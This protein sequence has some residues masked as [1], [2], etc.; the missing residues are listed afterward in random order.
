MQIIDELTRIDPSILTTPPDTLKTKTQMIINETRS[1]ISTIESLKNE[2]ISMKDKIVES[3]EKIRNSKNLPYLV[4]HVAE[5][6]SGD[7][8]DKD[9]KK[10]S[11][12]D[13]NNLDRN[14]NNLDRDKNNLDRDSA[15]V[16]TTTRTSSFLPMA[17]LVETKDLRPG[18]LVALHKETNVIFYKLPPDYD[19]RVKAMEVVERPADTYDDIGGLERQIEELNEAVV[20]PLTHPDKFTRLNIKMPKGVLLYGP[21]GTGKTL[22]ARAVAAR[23][24]ATFLK[25]AG[26]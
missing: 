22:L 20:L 1:I 26:P 6:Y 15:I 18:D 24:N 14:R 2:I 13:K 5:V 25:L 12:R 23:T 10:K 16:N 8:N 19:A 4:G 7:K 17:G 3:N 21:P 11:F 9:L